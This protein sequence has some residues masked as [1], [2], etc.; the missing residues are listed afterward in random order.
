MPNEAECAMLRGAEAQI[1]E[2]IVQGSDDAII[3]KTLDGIVTSWNPAAARIFGYSAAEMIGQSMLRV[4]P[5]DRVD[6]E[7][8]IL[9]RLRRGE[10]V[11]HF[12]T[13]RLHRSG[14][15]IHLSVTIS[16]MRDS[17][18]RIVGAS[19]I[20][21]DVTERVERDR[22]I[23]TQAHIDSLTQLP[24]RRM[25]AHRLDHALSHAT[26]S[27]QRLALLFI[28]LDHFKTINDTLGHALGDA[29]LVEVARRIRACV[30]DS[31]TV[32][33][34]GGDEFTVLVHDDHDGFELNAII[35]RL[36]QRLSQPF[37]LAGQLLRVS[38]SIGIA[39][40]PEHGQ[41]A[42]SLLVSA[43]CAM[44]EAKRSGRGRAR[45]FAPAQMIQL[46]RRR[47][48]AVALPQLIAE[49]TLDW[50]CRLVRDLRDGRHL[51]G[52]LEPRW[53]HSVHGELA[54]EEIE[55]AAREAGL[56]EALEA[57]LLHRALAL[58]DEGR[59]QHGSE[60][61]VGV[62]ISRAALQAGPALLDR[63]AEA[64]AAVRHSPGA[65]LALVSGDALVDSGD[66]GNAALRALATVGVPPAVEG[67]GGPRLGLTALAGL[68][69]EVLLAAA[70]LV[71]GA[72]QR[73]AN[74]V[75]L[76]AAAA[77]AAS[78]LTT[79]LVGSTTQA[80]PPADV[81]AA[82]GMQAVAVENDLLELNHPGFRADFNH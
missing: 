15:P 65:L 11:E 2:A 10:K 5:A 12:E 38:A 62:R 46:Q 37:M 20:A 34:M 8:D 47:A 27:D 78:S 24:N 1:L 72:L 76:C 35:R 52:L 13:I 40:H 58:L 14:L 41:S 69:P 18:G 21:R 50:R 55:A 45:Q 54:A 66:A 77:R 60:W 64:L 61:R 29:L 51:I 48:L 71:D 42:E 70:D 19:K 28:D 75:Q 79:V 6:E 81:L 43:D 67:W 53:A 17:S 63:W 33:R 39:C 23:W 74:F 59:Q 4:F 22:L 32:A 25:F 82:L 56:D 26:E 57:Q 3:T 9:A 49:G 73:R 31:D 7:A 16:P 36:N 68:E 30:R 44:Y 80:A